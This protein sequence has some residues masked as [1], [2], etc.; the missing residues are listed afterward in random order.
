MPDPDYIR[1]LR[2]A[3]LDLMRDSLI[4]KLNQDS[5]LPSSNVDGYRADY[6]EQGWD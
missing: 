2:A 4:G 3:Y 5:A 1:R 6:R